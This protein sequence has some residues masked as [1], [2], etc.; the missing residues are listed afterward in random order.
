MSPPTVPAISPIP[1]AVQRAPASQSSGPGT[2][3]VI[4]LSAAG[5]GVAG[6][7][8]GAVFGVMARSA[9]SEAKTDCGGDPGHC[10]DPSSASL[11][12]SQALSDATVS[13]AAFVTGAALIAGGAFFYLTAGERRESTNEGVVVSA[14]VDS[15]RVGVVLVG[16]FR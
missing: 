11:R 1:Q 2:R 5:L 12:R 4:A 9:W 16:T 8:V 15:G 14:A 13:T 7:V 10:G 6:A 3:R